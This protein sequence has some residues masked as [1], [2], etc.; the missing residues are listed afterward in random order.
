MD[1]L[2]SHAAPMDD[3]GDGADTLAAHTSTTLVPVPADQAFEGFTDYIHLWWPLNIYSHF[4][5]GSHVSFSQGQM[6][7]EAEDGKQHLWGRILDFDMPTKI[8]IEF[9]LGMEGTA[10]TRLAFSFTESGTGSSVSLTHD[11]WARGSAGQ[12]QY[13]RYERWDEVIEYYARFMGAQHSNP[14]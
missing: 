8:V 14:M 5:P 4:G 10:P 7:E 13:E 3:H 9:S 12:A 2:F 6:L 1:G 11:G